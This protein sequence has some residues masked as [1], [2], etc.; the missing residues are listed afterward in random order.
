MPS[1]WN[2]FGRLAYLPDAGKAIVGVLRLVDDAGIRVAEVTLGRPSLED[3]FLRI[4]GERL[5]SYE[6]GEATAR[7][8]ER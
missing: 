8:A 2:L 7:R 1:S 4:T 6:D 3:V 5:Q